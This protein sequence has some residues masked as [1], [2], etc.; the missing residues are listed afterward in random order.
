MI[1]ENYKLLL[2]I[3]LTFLTSVVFVNVIAIM[4]SKS[5]LPVYY[6]VR[7][8]IMRV[9]KYSMFYSNPPSVAID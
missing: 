8:I 2:M 5:A 4:L 9:K 7:K 3:Y 1:A 6:I